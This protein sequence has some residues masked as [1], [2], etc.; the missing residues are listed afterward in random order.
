[1]AAPARAS[2]TAAAPGRAIAHVDAVA[3]ERN[4]ASLKRRL[5]AADL[6]AV[7]KADGYGHGAT[8]CARRGGGRR[9]D[10]ARGRDRRRGGGAAA[11]RHRRA[12]PR[13]GSARLAPSSELALEAD[14]DVVAWREDFA[15]AAAAVASPDRPARLHVK[16][17]TGMG[18][19]GTRDPEEAMRGRGAGAVDAGPGRGRPDD[20]LRDRGRSGVGVLRRAAGPF[21]AVRRGV[22]AGAS[23][24]R[25]ARGQ[26][27]GGAAQQRCALRHGALRDRDLRHGP[28]RRATRSA[29]GLEPALSLRSYVADVK[30]VARGRHRRLRAH[31]VGAR[32]TRTWQCCRSAT[33]TATGAGCPNA[34]EVL[35][36][37]RR[38]PVVGTV[39]MDNITVDV[40]AGTEVQRGDA[41]VLIG[42]EGDERVT[43]EELA[44]IL[45]TINYEITCGISARVPRVAGAASSRLDRSRLARSSAR[46]RIGMPARRCRAS[47]HGS[48]AGPVRDALL[49]R[50]VEDVDLVV[51]GERRAGRARAR[52]GGRRARVPA[53]GALRRLARDRARTARGRPTSRPLRG[54]GIE[55]DLALRD[56]TRQR[57]GRGR[58]TTLG[59]LI[60]PHGGRGGPG[61]GSPARRRPSIRSRTTR[62]ACC[63][64]RASHASWISTSNP[65]TEAL[66]RRA[67]RR[68][69]AVAPERS[70]YELRRLV[71]SDDP[72]R[73]I[74]LMD[75]AGLVRAAAAGARGAEGS[76]AE[77]LSPPRRVGT[78]ARGARA[79]GRD[80]ARPGGR[81]RRAAARRI[82]RRAARGRWPTSSRAG[83][84]CASARCCTTPASRRRA[85]SPPRAACCSGVTTASAPDM[86][87]DVRAGGCTRSTALGDY[88]AALAQ[89]HLRLGFLVH[90]RPLSRRHVYRYMRACEPVELEVTVLSAADRLATRGP[91]TREEAVGGHLELARE[92]AAE[93]LAW[94]DQPARRAPVRGDELIAELGI[95]PGPEVGRLLELVEEA[96]F[97]GEVAHARASALRRGCAP[98]ALVRASARRAAGRSPSHSRTP[99]ASVP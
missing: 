77:P 24:M 52:D 20:P 55:A 50:P 9:C 38:R 30:A 49:D 16:L 26:Q 45:G 94:R 75:D 56:F 92:L 15:R 11:R 44:R 73:G 88:L 86:A 66:A 57:D 65:R 23:R 47:R 8:A 51:A 64:W 87:R 74:E 3:V 67:A 79:A 40:G 2:Q 22:Q 41:A 42:T 35:I 31:L 82:A 10:V 12:D 58:S 14:A 17:D 53:V 97:A 37:G 83:R 13:D 63:A 32:A 59:A 96:A 46:V 91:R 71:A 7:V 54:D 78:H 89:H 70:F 98:R 93:A 81:V 28:V 18:R 6:C 21:Q 76:R 99:S 25:R 29:R 90:E 39:S 48:S 95:E 62:C 5:G 33:A 72:V 36:R 84:R 80:R 34:A 27:R 1:M 85:R 19:L 4:C 60:D 61:A 68:I 43:A 69:D